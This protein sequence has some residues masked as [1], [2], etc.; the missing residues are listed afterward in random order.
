MEYL[1][2]K[3]H[4]FEYYY[5]YFSYEVSRQHADFQLNHWDKH[6][7]PHDLMSCTLPN[8]HSIEFYMHVG[9]FHFGRCGYH[10]SQN[11]LHILVD[12]ALKEDMQFIK[13]KSEISRYG[14]CSLPGLQKPLTLLTYLG[15]H[16]QATLFFS[17]LWLLT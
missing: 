8:S 17:S 3:F 11:L 12:L 7:L 4:S 6:N 9:N 5:G 1:C 10:D 14:I 2:M 15:G 13:E 16:T